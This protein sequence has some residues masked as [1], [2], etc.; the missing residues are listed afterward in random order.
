MA[1][2]YL[3]YPFD[4]DLFIARWNAEPDSEKTALLDSGVMV[5]DPELA[6]RLMSS[7]NFGTIPF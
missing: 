5:E 2:T 1:K 3:N 4:D 7:G 6:S